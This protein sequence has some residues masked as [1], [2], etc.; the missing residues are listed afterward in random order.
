MGSGAGAIVVLS[1]ATLGHLLSQKNI[2]KSFPRLQGVSKLLGQA[3]GCRCAKATQSRKARALNDFKAMIRSWP[4]GDK[5]RFKKL[6]GAGR[7]RLFIGKQ[8]YE[9]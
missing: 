4:V 3:G 7:V 5:L 9:F 1:N 6:L 2:L 8:M